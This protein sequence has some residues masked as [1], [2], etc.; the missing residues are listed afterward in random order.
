MMGCVPSEETRGKRRKPFSLECHHVALRCSGLP[1]LAPSLQA[2]SR[3][4]RFGIPGTCFL[5]A[6]ES[7]QW[8]LGLEREV[9]QDAWQALQSLPF[10]RALGLSMLYICRSPIPIMLSVPII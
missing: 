1:V 2:F 4:I 7:P 5:W 6:R 9:C 3:N 8:G 10:P